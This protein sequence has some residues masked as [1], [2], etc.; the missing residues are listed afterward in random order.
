MLLRSKLS[1]HMPIQSNL[2][3]PTHEIIR[4]QTSLFITRK[5]NKPLKALKIARNETYSRRNSTVLNSDSRYSSNC[6]NRTERWS[7][8]FPVTLMNLIKLHES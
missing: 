7:S 5:A 3:H 6:L 1:I 2:L 8:I 4:V